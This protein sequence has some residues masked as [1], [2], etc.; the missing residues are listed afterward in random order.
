ML[1][2]VD[3]P[4]IERE[5]AAIASALHHGQRVALR[6]GAASEQVVAAAL[7][8]LGEPVVIA[9]VP[10]A[11]DQVARTVLELARTADPRAVVAIDEALRRPDGRALAID[12][13]D[14]ALRGRRVVVERVDRFAPDSRDEV[15]N[16]LFDQQQHLARWVLDRADLVSSPQPLFSWRG[17]ERAFTPGEAPVGLHN[18]TAC[19]THAQW[20]DYEH[21]ARAYELALQLE[22][23]EVIE[24]GPLMRARNADGL[25]ARLW[26]VLPEGVA[27]LLKTLAIHGRPMCEELVSQLPNFEPSAFERGSA[28]A[29]WRTRAGAVVV[30]PAWTA[31]CSRWLPR[32]AITECHH[33]LADAFA[34]E[35]L[36]DDP[37]S[38]R[39][40]LLML[41]AHRHLVLAGEVERAMHYARHG[42]ELVVGHARDLSLERRYADAA[43]LYERLLAPSVTLAP[44]LRAY[45]RHY[46][47]YNRAHA[48]PEFE[49]VVETARG[50]EASLSDWPENAIFWSRAVRS[51]FLAGESAHAR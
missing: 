13:L 21:D 16:A 22:V 49:P 50:Y 4:V 45:A 39:A 11:L 46:L 29:L 43:A 14:G 8:A 15:A 2:L 18:G 34:R 1:R 42:A 37:S 19:P 3:A 17:A 40:G 7:R 12:L 10:A 6:C 24:D 38:R 28:L 9:Q 26:D 33:L 31:W 25:R 41:E 36:P 47:H 32:P 30:D 27:G 48:R 51:W 44:R 23:M 20:S 5:A 35:V